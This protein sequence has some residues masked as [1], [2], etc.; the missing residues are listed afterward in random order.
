MNI[1]IHNIQ[2]IGVKAVSQT[3]DDSS[4]RYHYQEFDIVDDNGIHYKISLFFDKA[5]TVLPV[6]D[7]NE[8]DQAD[9]SEDYMGLSNVA[10]DIF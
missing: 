6:G 7:R 3:L 4:E 10:L 2:K 1:N 5:S 8:L 9:S